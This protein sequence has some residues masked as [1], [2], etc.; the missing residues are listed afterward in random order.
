MTQKQTEKLKPGIYQIYWSEHRT[1][2]L[3][4]VGAMEDGGRWLA[5]VNWPLPTCSQDV[6]EHVKKAHLLKAYSFFIHDALEPEQE[7]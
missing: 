7:A 5:P 6:W 3:A 2:T 4:A 1:P